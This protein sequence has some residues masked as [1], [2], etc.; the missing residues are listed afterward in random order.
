MSMNDTQHQIHL[1]RH[2]VKMLEAQLIAE[3]EQSYRANLR[4]V[5]LHQAAQA[6]ADR[7]RAALTSVCRS[8]AGECTPKRLLT[9]GDTCFHEAAAA[10]WPDA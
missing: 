3:R 1:L 4:D 8:M 2:Q 5:E 7:L 9:A 6:D 10:L